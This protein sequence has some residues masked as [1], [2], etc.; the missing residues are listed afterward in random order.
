MI[1]WLAILLLTALAAPLC[2]KTQAWA[3]Q[4]PDA[5]PITWKRCSGTIAIGGT[6]Q[7][8]SLGSGPLRGFF[9]QNPSTATESLF[10]DPSGTASS[11]AGTS[12]E[13]SVG[14]SVSFGPATIFVGN[15]LSIVAA[16]G[17]HAFV[18]NSGQ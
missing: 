13:L 12:P 16:T 6:A 5:R 3:D 14:Q 9:L 4:Q 8:L 2:V 1:R 10:Y 17:G 18:C 11:T 15:S 7:N